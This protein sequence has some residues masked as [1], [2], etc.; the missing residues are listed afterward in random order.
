MNKRTVVYAFLLFSVLYWFAALKKGF[1]VDEFYSWVYSQ[2]STFLEILTLHDTG[3][4]HPPLFHL[5]Q[6]I[7]QSIFPFYHPFQVRLV[8]YI[9]GS[10]FI[11]ILTSWLLQKN[12]PRFFI[13]SLS[14][15]AAILNTFVLARMWGLV[16]LASLFILWAG[17]RYLQ[18]KSYRNFFLVIG[19]FFL[20]MVSDYNFILLFPFLVFIAL[21]Q[22]LSNRK[23]KLLII[24][25]ALVVWQIF[26]ILDTVRVHEGVDYFLFSVFRGLT[27]I[28]YEVY[29]LLFDWGAQELAGLALFLFLIVLFYE[30][31]SSLKTKSEA[32]PYLLVGVVFILFV[33]IDL[34]IRI[35]VLRIRH[36]A[37]IFV[38]LGGAYLFYFRKK[39][40]WK[41]FHEILPV[42][43]SLFSA[44]IILISL[45]P[46]FYRT[47]IHHKFAIILI[48]FLVLF[49][50]N[51]STRL[52]K[53]VSVALVVA[54]ILYLS[55]S[56]VDNAY[57][58]PAVEENSPVIFFSPGAIATQYL[59][60]ES[61]QK[62]NPYVLDLSGFNK[63]C[64][65]CSLGTDNIPFDELNEFF[66]VGS[67]AFQPADWIPP[68]FQLQN[69]TYP[70]FTPV[71][72][73]IHAYFTPIREVRYPLYRFV[74]K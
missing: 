73:F 50:L 52:L 34:L 57:V 68:E 70:G 58:A 20:G 23:Y 72:K 27:K 2:R 15:S 62:Q 9:L 43:L 59:K 10:L 19:S 61:F 24:G 12:A 65:V 6:K 51:Y 29:T 37:I 25:L 38:L 71:D 1:H 3:I 17:E 60:S 45:D 8:N 21:H 7:V 44:L 26:L 13:F 66:V 63:A 4:G 22:F 18:H 14:A 5:G 49:L 55:S 35:D 47:L 40:R 39:L 46:F 31:K 36:V 53:V 69:M 33:G 41:K 48:P 74:R 54:G 11:V 42:N 56:S 28:S 64:R 67:S 32:S 30:M 16:C